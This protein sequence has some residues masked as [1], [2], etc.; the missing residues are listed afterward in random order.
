M[1]ASPV[2]RPRPRLLDAF[3][4]LKDPRRCLGRVLH[5]LENLL[6]ISICAVL[7][8]AENWV[9]IALFGE[10]K[11]SFFERFLD[12]EYGIPSH[13]TF[14]HVFRRLRPEA[15]ARCFTAW[16]QSLAPLKVGEVVALDGKT[17][18]AT[19]DGAKGLEALHVVSAWAAENQL[20][21]GQIAT[22]A[23]SNEITAIPELLE[24]LELQDSIVT[25]DAM[26][27]QK[28][29]AQKV[30]DQG[31][32][33]VLALKANH[34]KFLLEVESFFF[35]GIRDGRVGQDIDAWEQEPEMEHGRVEQR[36]V[37]TASAVSECEGFQ[38]WP[39]LSSV[40]RMESI[41][42]VEGKTS[43]ENLYYISS[44]PGEDAEFLGEI[45]RS[46]WGIE[47]RL[48]WVLDVTFREDQ[49]RVRRDHG[50]TNL[51]LIRKVA[52]NLIRQNKT[53]K[54]SVQSK[55]HFAGWDERFL[56]ELL[57]F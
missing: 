53:R 20:V 14:N 41:R 36:R 51:A 50:G 5:P 37:W 27:T 7:S 57:R 35:E 56:L 31:A 25:L 4:S 26:G 43:I 29:I 3:A 16:A 48:H 40:M 44:L 9:E 34:P 55:R 22:A 8:G 52:L 32:D 12:L 38:E 28:E 24:L 39:G 45:K 42:T 6:F 49:C 13:D 1:T 18:R 19:R 54:G 10:A 30:L 23:D 21:L 47:N 46:H 15:F 17:L 33:Y 2:S 11:R